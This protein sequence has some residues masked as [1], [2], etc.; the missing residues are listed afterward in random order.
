[1]GQIR[2]RGKCFQIRYYRDGRRIEETT[3]CTKW[4]AARDVLRDRENAISHGVPITAASTRLRRR[5]K[6]S[7]RRLHRERQ[8]FKG[9]GAAADRQAPHAGVWR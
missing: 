6:G 3:E 7:P 9:L 5:R 2:K 1:M 8:T 4:E